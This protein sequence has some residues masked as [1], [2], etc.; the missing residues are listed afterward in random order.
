MP[1]WSSP[2]DVPLLV[3]WHTR[4]SGNV[5]ENVFIYSQFSTSHPHLQFLDLVYDEVPWEHTTSIL[6]VGWL[7]N[8]EK[9]QHLCIMLV[10]NV[11]PLC[12]ITSL[13]I[14]HTYD[15]GFLCITEF[16]IIHIF[17]GGYFNNK[18]KFLIHTAVNNSWRQSIMD[19]SVFS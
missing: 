14:A 17:Q 8:H 7:N 19:T 6:F 18:E 2:E 9:V 1:V 13:T 4:H 16:L 15:Y 11:H 3:Q 5:I 12:K 10:F